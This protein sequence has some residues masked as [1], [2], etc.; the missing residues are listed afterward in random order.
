MMLHCKAVLGGVQ[1]VWQSEQNCVVVDYM[2][3]HKHHRYEMNS[4][5]SHDSEL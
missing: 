4:V 2:L 1:L 5:L 3:H